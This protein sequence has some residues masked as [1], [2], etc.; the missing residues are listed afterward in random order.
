ML[1]TKGK[2]IY[3]SGDTGY[4]SHFKVAKSLFPNLDVAIIGVGA[5]KPEWFMAP[6]HISP[7]DAVKAVGDLGAKVM[8]PMHYGTLDLSDEPVGEPYRILKTM[9]KEGKIPGTLKA[10]ELGENYRGF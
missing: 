1:Q 4:G 10:L 9:E 2:T 6:N 8:I 3:F 5:Y 7:Q